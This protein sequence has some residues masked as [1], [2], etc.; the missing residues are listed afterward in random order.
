[1]IPDI[2]VQINNK[3]FFGNKDYL[4]VSVLIFPSSFT[5]KITLKNTFLITNYNAVQ[6]RFLYGAAATDN[7]HLLSAAIFLLQICGVAFALAL[8]LIL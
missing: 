1:M 5:D 8:K 6:K 4:L 7:T 3:T 2:Y